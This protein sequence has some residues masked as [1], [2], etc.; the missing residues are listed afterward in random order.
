[1]KSAGAVLRGRAMESIS[2]VLTIIIAVHTNHEEINSSPTSRKKDLA[3]LAT[4]TV[5][6]SSA[7]KMFVAV[8]EAQEGGSKRKRNLTKS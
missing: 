7:K 5:P 2:S 8:A 6:L 3:R 4:E 1:M